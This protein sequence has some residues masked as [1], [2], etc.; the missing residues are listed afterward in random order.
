MFEEI[1]D[2]FEMCGGAVEEITGRCFLEGIFFGRG[3]R[4]NSHWENSLDFMI[5]IDRF[6]MIVS[7]R[8][9]FR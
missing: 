1:I 2:F 5:S 7:N 6:G 3:R 8:F 4:I 9:E